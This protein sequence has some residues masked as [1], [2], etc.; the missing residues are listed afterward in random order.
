ML[1][2]L[3]V[4]ELLVITHFC[5]R[6]KLLIFQTF[7]KLTNCWLLVITYKHGRTQVMGWVGGRTS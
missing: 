4:N 6:F 2:L 5:T 1:D 3:Y 7:L